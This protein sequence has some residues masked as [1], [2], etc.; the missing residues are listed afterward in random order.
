MLARACMS[1]GLLRRERLPELLGSF[2][3]EAADATLP[4]PLLPSELGPLDK[5]KYPVHLR[6]H[7]CAA[8][9]HSDVCGPRGARDLIAALKLDL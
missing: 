6:D 8:L 5:E 3:H 7:V 4:D 1:R 2:F 9:L